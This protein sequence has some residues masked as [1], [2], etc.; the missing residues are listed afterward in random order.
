M[1]DPAA[2]PAGD[3]GAPIRA[4]VLEQAMDWLVAL[5]SGVADAEELAACAQWRAA[6]P[7]HERA[8]RRLDTLHR[9]LRDS[10]GGLPAAVA[11]TTL[12]QASRPSRRLALK[13]LAGLALAGGGAWWL[14]RNTPWRAWSAD[15]AAATGERRRLRLDGGGELL[16]NSRG[17][18]D[19]DGPRILLRRGELLVDAASAGRPLEV[20]L[21]CGVVVRS[22]GGRFCIGYGRLGQREEQ[23]RHSAQLAVLHGR[24]HAANAG[25]GV[26]VEA[27]RQ[28][29]LDADRIDAGEAL[30]P[31]TTAWI[32]GMLLA[33]R[34]PLR[35]VVTELARYRRGL[36]YCDDAVAALPVSGAFPLAD[37]D[38]VLAAL[39]RVLP[40]RIQR[41]GRYWVSLQ[42]A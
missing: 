9:N 38:A 24:V 19:L 17:A 20:V 31:A 6:D 10:R 12:Q 13:S 30:A 27:G 28:L 16:L 7:E 37:V 1:P 39:A 32:D 11:R 34:L 26:Q 15:Y 22:D 33:E 5:Q 41:H 14:Q 29:H 3:D 36:L 4:E 2:L 42:P 8:W 40:V 23:R 18:I 21:D 35:A 25:A